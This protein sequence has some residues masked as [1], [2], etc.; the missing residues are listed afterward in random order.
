MR[1]FIAVNFSEEIR[2]TLLKAI[3]EIKSQAISG[4]FTRPENLHLTL[5]FIG[6]SDHIKEI[7]KVIDS[8]N[9]H[10]FEL[11]I[12]GFGH[13]GNLHW[14]GIDNNPELK[15]L[16]ENLRN[17]LR[18]SGFNIEDKAFKPHITIARELQTN[19]PVRL[20]VPKKSM[21]VSRI[22]LM[23]SERINGKLTYTEIYGRSLS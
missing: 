19:E 22:S 18:D 14:V 3:Q 16:A 5:A 4:N 1:L 23:K 15:V 20:S 2:G 6:E 13:F 21:T 10:A 7:Q 9:A 17:G 8:L 12:G 11:T